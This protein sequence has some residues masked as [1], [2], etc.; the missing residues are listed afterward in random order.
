MLSGQAYKQGETWL[1]YDGDVMDGAIKKL[2]GKLLGVFLLCGMLLLGPITT[3]FAKDGDSGSGNSG[4]GSSN[5]GSGG[6]N[7]GSGSSNSGPG[8]S[9]SGRDDDRDED[10]DDDNKVSDQDKASNAVSR[11]KA[12]PLRDVL[13]LVRSKV[14][15]DVLRVRLSRSSGTYFYRITVLTEDGRYRDVVVDAE[16]SRIVSTRWR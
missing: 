8:S 5:S 7:S 10:E 14:P 16:R 12:K 1:R 4:S 11:G 6:S 15:G 9:N 3:A 2:L 13:R